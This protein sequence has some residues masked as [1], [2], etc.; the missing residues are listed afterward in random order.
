MCS[1]T[2][3]RAIWGKLSTA[4]THH[5]IGI[6]GPN[7]CPLCVASLET[8]EHILYECRFTRSIYDSIFSI[9]SIHLCYDMGFCSLILQ[10]QQVVQSK[11]IKNLWRLAFITTIW[12]IWHI[13]CRIIFDDITPSHHG[14]M[15]IILWLILEAQNFKMGTAHGVDDLSICRRLRV[16]SV[17]RPP[18]TAIAVKWRPPPPGCYKLNVDGSYDSGRIYAGCV[19][20]NSKGLFVAAFHHPGQRYRF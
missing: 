2:V 9:F 18:K 11:Q 6:S 12:V 8:Q 1:T 14:C 16:L 5:R 7:I 20:R 15:I 4:D 10:A 3:W 13:R 17:P 19:I